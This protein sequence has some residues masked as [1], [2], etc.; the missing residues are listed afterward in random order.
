MMHSHMLMS[1]VETL[2]YGEFLVK[3]RLKRRFLLVAV[4]LIAILVGV[5]IAVDLFSYTTTLTIQPVKQL[6][7]GASTASWT[8]YVNDQDQ[9][10][11]VPG[12]TSQPTFDAADSST[13]AFNVTTDANKACAVEINLA[14]AMSSSDFSDFQITVL[15]WTGSAWSPST[16]Y[17]TATGSTPLT[18]ID[19]LT[20]TPGYIHQ[21]VSTS[22]YYLVAITYT[23]IQ[24]NPGAPYTVHLQYT[25]LPEP[26]T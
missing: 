15:H 22:T 25:P 10:Q 24:E 7:Q 4:A 19:G 2:F 14:E 26:P 17:T 11:Y 23:Y 9:T 18:Y 16:L 21:A 12:A 5:A 13:Y 20:T 6:S 3:I 8:I 1:D